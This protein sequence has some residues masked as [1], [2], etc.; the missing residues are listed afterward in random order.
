MDYD[1]APTREQIHRGGLTAQ[2]EHLSRRGDVDAAGKILERISASDAS[3]QQRK[4]GGLQINEAQRKEDESIKAAA[5][6]ASQREGYAA[7]A[8][9]PPDSPEAAKMIAKLESANRAFDPQGAATLEHTKTQNESAKYTHARAVNIDKIYKTLASTDP[10]AVGIFLTNDLHDGFKY[11]TYTNPENGNY[12]IVQSTPGKDDDRVVKSYLNKKQFSDEVLGGIKEHAEIVT[13]SQLDRDNKLAEG[14]QHNQGTA[15]V[16]SIQVGGRAGNHVAVGEGGVPLIH[17]PDGQGY[18]IDDGSGT[19]YPAGAPVFNRTTEKAAKPEVSDTA[20]KNVNAW[21][22]DQVAQLHSD[23][24]RDPKKLAEAEAA[25]LGRALGRWGLSTEQW[26]GSA[27][28]AA[29]T[30]DP[31]QIAIRNREAAEKQRKAAGGTQSATPAPSATSAPVPAAP[32][33]S[34][35]LAALEAWGKTP[36]GIAANAKRAIRDK[37]EKDKVATD[38]AADQQRKGLSPT[39]ASTPTLEGKKDPAPTPAPAKAKEPAPAPAPVKAKE[40]APAPA[41]VKAKETVSTGGVAAGATKPAVVDTAKNREITALENVERARIALENAVKE[42]ARLAAVAKAG[43]DK[44]AEESRKRVKEAA[45]RAEERKIQGEIIALEKAER[46]RIA[47][48]NAAKE[49][50]KEPTPAPVK[51]KGLTQNQAQQLLEANKVL[52]A[53]QEKGSTLEEMRAQLAVNNKRIAAAQKAVKE[54]NE[55]LRKKMQQE[56]ENR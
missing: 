37:L 55:K 15:A 53:A 47:T 3:E 36:E 21:I 50:A 13:K 5:H 16:A 44:R 10:A 42:E 28:A 43:A 26:H 56:K 29:P 48:E 45:D 2:Y 33:P 11:G 14:A 9:L 23:V 41:P 20:R 22:D 40:P 54:E 4:L 27:S 32:M 12:H 8:A 51:V 38:A 7:V 52:R 24:K 34:K 19:R 49:R 31:E 46:G 6:H 39:S 18:V 35:E 17:A 25:I 1:T 30:L